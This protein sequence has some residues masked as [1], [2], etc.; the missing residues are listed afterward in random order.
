M[1]PTIP[2]LIEEFVN[3][4]TGE[5]PERV[6]RVGAEAASGCGMCGGVP[7]S[8]TCFVRRFQAALDQLRALHAEGEGWRPIASATKDGTEV[9]L[10]GANR[11]G[12]PVRAVGR[13]RFYRQD[14]GWWVGFGT[15]TP[16]H[17]MP[18]PS[19]PS[20]ETPTKGTE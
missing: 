19:P 3:Y 8:T 1:T 20:I 2:A 10:F 11:R 4:W 7:H 14:Y 15:G 13:W 18:L 9:I 17:W 6:K 12:K 5:N 16:T